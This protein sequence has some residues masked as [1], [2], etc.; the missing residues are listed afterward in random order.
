MNN[1]WYANVPFETATSYV[2]ATGGEP[3][4][5][6]NITWSIQIGCGPSSDDMAV[7]D[8][9]YGYQVSFDAS[10]YW[11][12]TP[13]LAGSPRKAS[14]LSLRRAEEAEGTPEPCGDA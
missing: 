7:A 1:T 9:A 4:T 11:E 13:S 14:L 5:R 8:E 6:A 12:E 10:G 2:R 3:N